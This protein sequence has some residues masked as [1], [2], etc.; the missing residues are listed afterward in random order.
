MERRLNIIYKKQADW[1][2]RSLIEER[3]GLSNGL[4]WNT[5]T[6]TDQH[7]GNN[8]WMYLI[9]YR[10]GLLADMRDEPYVAKAWLTKL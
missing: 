8:T 6:N 2:V 5:S 10:A 1:V 4:S 9:E 7:L 3:N